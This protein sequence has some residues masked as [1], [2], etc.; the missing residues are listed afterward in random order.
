MAESTSNEKINSQNQILEADTGE[1]A[2]SL[3]EQKVTES[4]VTLAGKK[5]KGGGLA[6]KVR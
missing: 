6:K 4:S 2:V 5:K 1:V 3:E